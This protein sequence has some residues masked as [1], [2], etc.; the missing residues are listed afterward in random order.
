ML[1]LLV[2]VV[3]YGCSIGYNDTDHSVADSGSDGNFRTTEGKDTF[4]G[5]DFKHEMRYSE[6]NSKYYWSL[7]RIWDLWSFT[8]QFTEL[9]F[10]I[11]LQ[12]LDKIMQLVHLQLVHIHTGFSLTVKVR[13]VYYF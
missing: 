1:F 7:I 4:T 2:F 5:T 13:E 3:N 8:Y 11:L 12:H 10:Q 6:Q 9:F